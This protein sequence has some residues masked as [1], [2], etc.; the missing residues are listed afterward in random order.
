M[1]VRFLLFDW[2]LTPFLT[3]SQSYHGGQF[4]FSC[5]SL[6]FSHQFSTQQYSQ[7]TGCFSYRL[8]P[9]NDWWKTNEV[10]HSDFCHTSERELAEQ[11]L[12]LT[13][14]GLTAYIPTEA[15]KELGGIE[16]SR[17]WCKHTW[18]DRMKSN[19]FFYHPTFQHGK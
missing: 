7:A 1:K 4:T 10:C 2:G 5:V 17:V 13:T 6:F 8:S 15:Q 9:F 12:N 19:I 3:F 18:T 11:G 14:P 16:H